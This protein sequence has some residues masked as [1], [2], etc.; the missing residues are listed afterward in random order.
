[1]SLGEGIEEG[2]PMVKVGTTVGEFIA[3]FDSDARKVGVGAIEDTQD[4]LTSK[5]INPRV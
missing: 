1:M 3:S 4:E 2:T 5:V